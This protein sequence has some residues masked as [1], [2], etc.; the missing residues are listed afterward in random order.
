MRL[1]LV[2]GA[3]GFFDVEARINLLAWV[4][5]IIRVEDGFSLF[6]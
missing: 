5:D 1:F 4:E 2:G 6:K 3:H